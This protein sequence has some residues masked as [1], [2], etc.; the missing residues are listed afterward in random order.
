MDYDDKFWQWVS[1]HA[2]D[3]PSRLRLKYGAD[4]E[5]EI[6]Q[7]E[8]RHKYSGK[9]P[10]T[11]AACA[12]FYFPTTLSAEQA[13]SDRLAEFHASLIDT[14]ETVADL[15]A[16][17]G[18]DTLHIAGK[19]SH[20]TAV[21]RNPTVAD[22]LAHNSRELGINNISVICNDCRDYIKQA[23]TFDT[24]FID[25]A[26]RS[27]DGGR[28]Y[29]LN[30]CEPDVTA[31]LPMV[32]VS[33]K[34][35][36]IKMSPMLDIT[37]TLKLLP[38][39]TEFIILGTSTECK[40]LIAVTDFTADTKT[41]ASSVTH[42]A[43]TLLP[44]GRESIFEFSADDETKST[45][46]YGVPEVGNYIYEPYPAAMK[47]G[48]VKLLG[49]R[50]G[51]TKIHPNTHIYH[52]SQLLYDYP[53]EAFKIK[54]IL[55]YKSKH[56]KRLHSQWP[57]IDITTRNFGLSADTLRAKLAVK[58]GGDERLFAVTATGEER[59][60]IIVERITGC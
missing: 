24:V 55:P 36:I 15:T 40:E 37:H 41:G 2:T 10:K 43:I 14:G 22:A 33:C 9:F 20:I 39:G 56:I 3:N 59:L 47:T 45:V 48:A 51:L 1:Y 23:A 54:E 29:A 49:T 28:V 32:C 12:R 18:I 7:V 11:L 21:E 57:R 8:C 5:D 13:T 27:A 30:Q 38:D 60:M 53:G 52:S 4:R 17:L 50:F 19:A 35:S 6:R 16:G 42:K 58:D 31:I 44:S 26:R 25:P 46:I 34:R